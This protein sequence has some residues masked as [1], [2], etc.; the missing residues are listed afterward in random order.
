MVVTYGYKEDKLL[1]SWHRAGVCS[2][3]FH[4]TASSSSVLK[5]NAAPCV[6]FFSE[7]SAVALLQGNASL[8]DR[9]A[10]ESLCEC[11]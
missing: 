4:P 2:F 1:G 5:N 11:D 7:R 10:D 3:D 9:L 8:H 6:V